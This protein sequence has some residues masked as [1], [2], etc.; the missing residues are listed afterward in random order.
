MSDTKWGEKFSNPL[1]GETLIPGIR[2]DGTRDL[3]IV[4]TGVSGD[5]GGHSVLN[6]DGTPRFIRDT[7]GRI[8][9]NDRK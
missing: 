7:D 9:A 1:S 4:Q 3:K 2:P 6:P 8:I 5:L